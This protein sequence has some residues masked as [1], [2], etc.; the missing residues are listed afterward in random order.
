V[1]DLCR[2]PTFGRMLSCYCR[3][4]RFIE[5]RTQTHYTERVCVCAWVRP[6][7]QRLAGSALE[8][9]LMLW[10]RFI[11]IAS[12][13]GAPK[14]P[15]EPPGNPLLRTHCVCSAVLRTA[16]RFP[17]SAPVECRMSRMCSPLLAPPHKRS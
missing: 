7:E 6:F 12:P 11:F 14:S 9:Q 2:L 8:L 3:S 16:F 4:E 1:H 15:L 5:M 13:T 10:S 17:L